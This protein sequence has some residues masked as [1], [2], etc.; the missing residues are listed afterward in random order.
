MHNNNWS[1][2]LIRSVLNKELY[3]HRGLACCSFS[4]IR[5]VLNKELYTHRGLAYYS[6]SLMV[7][8]GMGFS[9]FH[10]SPYILSTSL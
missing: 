3:T 8:S 4:L 7:D 2:G 1:G 10:L 6:F 9:M 5:S